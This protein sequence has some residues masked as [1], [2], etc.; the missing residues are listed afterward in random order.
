MIIFK[1]CQQ[2]YCVFMVLGFRVAIGTKNRSDVRIVKQDQ[3]NTTTLK[4]LLE[5]E[6]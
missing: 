5:K 1:D 2:K 6:K 3:I 4:V